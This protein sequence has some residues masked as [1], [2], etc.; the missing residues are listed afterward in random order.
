[1]NTTTRAR[2]TGTLV[3]VY[4]TINDGEEVWVTYC[5][6]HGQSV[7]HQTK[8]LA[9]RHRSNPTGWC[10]ECYASA[11]NPE[12]REFSVSVGTLQFVPVAHFTLSA[13]NKTHARKL[14]LQV[15]ER[16]KADNGVSLRLLSV[17]EAD[18]E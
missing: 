10:S 13:P 3:S 8:S 18:G 1:M 17:K 2:E 16:I 5:E 6:E 11:P 4:D 7:D 9:I 15:L 14:A 12:R